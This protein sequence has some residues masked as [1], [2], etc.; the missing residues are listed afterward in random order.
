MSIERIFIG[1]NVSR[2][3]QYLDFIH[4]IIV[5]FLPLACRDQLWFPSVRQISINVSPPVIRLSYFRSF[6]SPC[7]YWLMKCL[8][9]CCRL[10]YCFVRKYF[11][12]SGNN[13]YK[14]SYFTWLDSWRVFMIVLVSFSSILISLLH[15]LTFVFGC[16]MLLC[17]GLSIWNVYSWFWSAY[18]T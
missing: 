15:N 11:G 16:L 3:A 6:L 8:Y 4:I 7:V 5:F 18:T 17:F 10:I 1:L 9:L 12:N 14:T 2:N 13:S